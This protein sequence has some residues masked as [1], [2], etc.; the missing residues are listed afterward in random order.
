MVT[1][2]TSVILLGAVRNP[3]PLRQQEPM[4]RIGSALTEDGARRARA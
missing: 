1:S 2:A 3:V 4:L